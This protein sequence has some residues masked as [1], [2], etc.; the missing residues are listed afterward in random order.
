MS[1]EKCKIT[2]ADVNR[3]FSKACPNEM[4]LAVQRINI[5]DPLMRAILTGFILTAE[6]VEMDENIGKTWTLNDIHRGVNSY[7]CEKSIP[8]KNM[9]EIV[10]V[11]KDL[12]SSALVDSGKCNGSTILRNYSLKVFGHSYGILL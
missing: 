6:V 8:P 5:L 12:V 1:H 2:M 7:F 4:N 3:I 9:E 10:F 11:L